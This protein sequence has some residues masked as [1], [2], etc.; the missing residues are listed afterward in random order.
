MSGFDAGFDWLFYS[1]SNNT[2]TIVDGD[3]NYVFSDTTLM[4]PSFLFRKN[5]FHARFRKIILYINY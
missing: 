2:R 5:I 3:L 1:P 4:G